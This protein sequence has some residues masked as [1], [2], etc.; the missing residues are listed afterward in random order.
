MTARILL[1][2]LNNRI[3]NI[4][5]QVNQNND[6]ALH[7]PSNEPLNM[8]SFGINNVA[9]LSGTGVALSGISTIDGAGVSLSGINT[10]SGNST[11]PIILLS[12]VNLN[13]KGITGASTI[14]GS[15]VDITNVDTLTGISTN[16]ISVLSTIDLHNKSILNVN[17]VA[18]SGDLNLHTNL[19]SSTI[20][21]MTNDLQAGNKSEIA[22]NRDNVKL[23]TYD[24]FGTNKN[25]TLDVNN[26]LTFNGG[27][28]NINNTLGDI[29][30]KAL[31]LTL[32]GGGGISF[33]DG[34]I[35]TSAS[36]H[37]G[38]EI[39]FNN[40]SL[41]DLNMSN[42]KI[43]NVNELSHPTLLNLTTNDENSII[44]IYTNKYGLTGSATE[45]FMD[46]T[47]VY[48]GSYDTPTSDPKYM[49]LDLN[50]DLTFTGGDQNITNSLGITLSKSFEL[51]QDEGGGIKFQDG[52]EIFT[53]NGIFYNPSS[54]DLDMDNHKITKLNSISSSSIYFDIGTDTAGKVIDLYT[55]KDRTGTSQGEVYISDAGV[56]LATY[57]GVDFGDVRDINLDLN[58]NLIFEGAGTNNIITNGIVNCKSVELTQGAGGN[59]KFQDGTTQ[60]TKAGQVDSVISGTYIDVD[61][62]DPIN[63]IVNLNLPTPIAE[64]TN[65]VLKTDDTG[66]I[67]YTTLGIAPTTF[68]CNTD[69]A[70]NLF[71]VLQN[72]GSSQG[73]QIIMSSGSFGSLG[74]NINHDNLAIIG[75]RCQPAITE[76]SGSLLV[77]G[78][79]I[80]LSN[81]QI[82]GIATLSGN[83]CRY[84]NC[85]F[86]QNTTIGSGSNTSYITVE[87]CE[88]VSGKTLT[89]NATLNLQPITFINCN[90]DGCTIVLNSSSPLQ[91]AFN[92]CSGFTALPLST[93]AT[94]VGL[95][96]VIV[97]STITA[98]NT[99]NKIILGT[100]RGTQGQILVSGGSGNDN[101]TTVAIGNMSNPST[102]SLDMNNFSISNVV[103]IFNRTGTTSSNN[104]TLTNGGGGKL[105]FADGT[106]LDSKP[107]NTFVSPADKNLN[108]AGFNLLNLPNLYGN[109]NSIN[110]YN[111]VVNTS[112]YLN[113]T[114]DGILKTWSDTDPNTGNLTQF[115]SN[116]LT[117]DGFQINHKNPT[118][119]N[120]TMRFYTDTD[121]VMKVKFGDNTVQ[122]TAYTGQF[123]P[124]ATSTLNL[125]N[126]NITNVNN[127]T[128]KSGS[129]GRITFSDGS[130]MT[131]A[132]SGNSGMLNPAIASLDMDNFNI[133]NV[134]N[135]YG[136]SSAITIGNRETN[137]NNIV[138]MTPAEQFHAWTDAD[139]TTGILTQSVSTQLDTN[140]FQINHKNPT[141]TPKN[142]K[143]WTD[144]DGIMKM[145]F[146]NN[147][148]QQTA[149][150][151]QFIPTATTDLNMNSKDITN[152][153][154]I[155][156]NQNLTI[157]V[158]HGG[159]AGKNKVYMDY[160]GIDIGTYL[161][162]N[163]TNYRGIKLDINNDL[164]FTN[165]DM[166]INNSVGTTTSANFTLTS[167]GATAGRLTFSDGTWLDTKPTG[168]GGGG[169]VNP[170]T[171]NLDMNTYDI[172]NA[173]RITI[174]AKDTNT[175]DLFTA[176]NFYDNAIF[177]ITT[178][179][180][181]CFN[182]QITLN[183][184]NP[185]IF[186]AGLNCNSVYG[187]QRNGVEMGG[188]FSPVRFTSVSDYPNFPDSSN[189]NFWNVRNFRAIET[190]P[191]SV[192]AN[193]GGG[194]SGSTVYINK[195]ALYKI[196]WSSTVY[197]SIY[198]A[199]R[200][201]NYTGVLGVGETT[202]DDA[203]TQR[204]TSTGCVIVSLTAG[205]SFSLEHYT[206]VGQTYGL[207]TATISAGSQSNLDSWL[208]V[209]TV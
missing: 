181:E 148:V 50:N 159:L 111:R 82:D 178:G 39:T 12:N 136:K 56:Y 141:S 5:A 11:N 13:N 177:R 193:L 48:I 126:N 114:N 165:G 207:G 155:Y 65:Q 122:Q 194:S 175:I 127:L 172:T 88:F 145:R 108:M 73:C 142:M 166:N 1:N 33:A 186:S 70:P 15:H 191:N 150:T 62:T 98:T 116:S 26:N 188:Q 87:N 99:M 90:F 109:T 133:S 17:N 115:V 91:I 117:T 20:N 137:T 79:R 209:E 205:S 187:Y 140:G 80:R 104:F 199:T 2:N 58:N 208:L 192:D 77:S 151:G 198:S 182:N 8:N 183:G 121:G 102:S 46:N 97:G 163:E 61:N 189:T 47:N 59:L 94:L 139:E 134:P 27:F 76:I 162:P 45:I 176:T 52:T 201:V 173:N 64:L 86:T 203:P 110:L 174:K 105:T 36:K 55:N 179:G 71:T 18:S 200:I 38:G 195:N 103:D 160:T 30:S 100:N 19:E 85:D 40:P 93:K 204:K 156:N 131:S 22:V 190:Y 197:A 32:N 164:T 63:P 24:S 153:L 3:N 69:T 43:I 106:F 146:G 4:Q 144:T 57:Q 83:S 78:T 171:E 60:S 101:W 51:T 128:L 96:V 202:T 180:I 120:R 37:G 147:T 6:D 67:S 168:G 130:F 118:S 16:P 158:N 107:V 25:I 138:F 152:V 41:V 89:V 167:G 28:Q 196:S 119:S 74:L 49:S 9:S 31:V 66:V 206:Q 149:Y 68:Y 185:S 29:H 124:T 157:N 72:V 169:F 44:D 154:G 34:T 113:I 35:Q 53:T 92:N 132:P 184:Y 170:A 21:L 143:F 75:P 84:S 14:T 161:S 123:I 7:N 81:L 54:G 135:I 42:N 23:G 95:N 112:A 129:N 10:L 125:N